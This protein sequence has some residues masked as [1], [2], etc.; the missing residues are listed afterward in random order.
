MNYLYHRVHKDM[1]GNILYPLNQL[2]DKFPDLY[3]Q[4]KKK[5]DGR[6]HVMDT[7]I[8]P[9]D[10]LWN[11][12]LFFSP[13]HPQEIKKALMEAGRKEEF[14]AQYYQINAD[15]LEQENT[16]IY[17]Y[18]NTIENFGIIP[19]D[20][21]YYSPDKINNYVSVPDKT[22]QYFRDAYEQDRRPLLYVGIPHILYKGTLDISN[23]PI[24]SV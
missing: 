20:F 13:V 17:L 8:T 6:E 12:V 10:C 5:Y 24:I 21:V 18:K 2:K 14:N 9:L 15:S 23:S 16:T 1:E 4:K 22:K 7:K 3:V 11:D 19:E